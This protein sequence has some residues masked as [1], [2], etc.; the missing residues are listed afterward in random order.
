M[1][2]IACLVVGGGILLF[3]RDQTDEEE[4]QSLLNISREAIE[5]LTLETESDTVSVTKEGLE[6]RVEYPLVDRANVRAIDALISDLETMQGTRSFPAEGGLATY[7]LDPPELRIVIH[8][9]TSGDTHVS[10]GKT[11]PAGSFRYAQIGDSAL[12]HIIDAGLRQRMEK[13]LNDLRSTALLVSDRAE[14]DTL[15]QIVAGRETKLV[16]DDEAWRLGVAR[17]LK[18]DDEAVS[19][20]L[21]QLQDPV[22]REF[23]PLSATTQDPPQA[24]WVFRSL[25]GFSA[26]TLWVGA[27]EDADL[28]VQSSTRAYDLVV[29]S[30]LASSFLAAPNVWRSRQLLPFYSYKANELIIEKPGQEQLVFSKS[31]DGPWRMGDWIAD[32]DKVVALVRELEDCRVEEFIED[33]ADTLWERSLSLSIGSRDFETATIDFG[34]LR[35]NQRPVF[36]H[37]L[38]GPAYAGCIDPD[39]IST[40]SLAWRDRKLVSF[41]PYQ[42]KEVEITTGDSKAVAKQKEYGEWRQSGAWADDVSVDDLLEAIHESRIV[43]FP[44]ELIE[45]PELGDETSIFLKRDDREDLDIHLYGVGADSL[46][47]RVGEGP[48]SILEPELRETIGGALKSS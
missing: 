18:A 43:R 2:L 26:E 36:A 29:D 45:L 13:G 19:S 3:E 33:E 30:S 48:I 37:H 34:S 24:M 15:I 35:E 31:E 28:I 4:T 41:Y 10:M 32:S 22:I 16:R 23:R 12:V 25:N 40:E 44:E 1:L 42:V 9:S 27:A 8:D 39:S 46:A 47:G 38:G 11:T 7:G 5:Q 14:I 20:F 17:N 6:W 21:R